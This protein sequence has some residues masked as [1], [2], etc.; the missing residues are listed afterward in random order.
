MRAYV[1]SGILF[2]LAFGM[3]YFPPSLFTSNRELTILLIG[4]FIGASL[5]VFERPGGCSGS[6]Q[7]K[8]EPPPVVHK[9]EKKP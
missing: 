4:A 2:L 3:M 1:T 5:I 9:E 6:C 8:P 7:K